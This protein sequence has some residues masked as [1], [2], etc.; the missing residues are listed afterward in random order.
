MYYGGWRHCNVGRLKN[1]FTGFIPFDD[2]EPFAEAVCSCVELRVAFVRITDALAIATQGV[3]CLVE[4]A[5]RRRQDPRV[6]RE[7]EGR[8]SDGE[9][10]IVDGL[11]LRAAESVAQY[12]RDVSTL[13]E[14]SEFEARHV[15]EPDTGQ[16]D[17]VA[18]VT[19]GLL[20]QPA[21]GP[22]NRLDG[23]I[24]RDPGPVL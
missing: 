6:V 24:A 4:L 20:E 9:V 22:N 13:F 10:G 19:A 21:T 2:G 17:V 23:G 8:L 7:I 16:H 18:E 12:A 11:R 5:L 1:D 15:V 14:N 3:E